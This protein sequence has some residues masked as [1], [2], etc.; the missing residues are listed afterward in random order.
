MGSGGAQYT[1]Q[2][3]LLV[4]NT[5]LIYIYMPLCAMFVWALHYG[6]F[7]NYILCIYI[8]IYIYITAKKERLF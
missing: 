4:P 7:H 2:S 8:Y 3:A 5:D 1:S 6:I